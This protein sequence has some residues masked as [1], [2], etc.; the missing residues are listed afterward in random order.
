MVPFQGS[1]RISGLLGL[2]DLNVGGGGGVLSWT[3]DGR[4]EKAEEW[5][6]G[7]EGAGGRRKKFFFLISFELR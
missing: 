7:G 4:L 1:A 6:E 3:E 5:K 2:L